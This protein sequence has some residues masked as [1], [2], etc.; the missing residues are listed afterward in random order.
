M[1]YEPPTLKIKFMKPSYLE[2]ARKGFEEQAEG[3]GVEGELKLMGAGAGILAI[4]GGVRAAVDSGEKLGETAG[5]AY[6][7]IRQH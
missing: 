5:K 2:M 1:G 3:L 4:T 7:S 6:V